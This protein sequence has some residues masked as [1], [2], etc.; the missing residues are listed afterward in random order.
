MNGF[1]LF[2]ESVVLLLDILIDGDE[3][4]VQDLVYQIVHQ[5]GKLLERM[6]DQEVSPDRL[7]ELNPNLLDDRPAQSLLSDENN[8]LFS[9][10]IHILQPRIVK[11]LL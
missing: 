10:L 4:G 2:P 11:Q 1:R 9:Q 3:M 7:Y 8:E 5:N 6:L